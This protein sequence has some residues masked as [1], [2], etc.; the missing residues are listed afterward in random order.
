MRN[1]QPSAPLYLRRAQDDLQRRTTPG[2][3]QYQHVLAGQVAV[4]RE[5]TRESRVPGP[6]DHHQVFLH[7]GLVTEIGIVEVEIVD[8]QVQLAGGQSHD[9]ALRLVVL[10][11]Q[12]DLRCCVPQL[13]QQ[14]RQ[15][16]GLGV[17]VHR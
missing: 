6:A 17:V 2:T 4:Q 12:H 8:G 11:F 14:R 16:H 5:S 3:G 9:Q 1:V 15:Q 10:H 13:L 7:Q